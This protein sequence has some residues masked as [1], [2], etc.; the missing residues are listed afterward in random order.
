MN[1]EA[2]RRFSLEAA[3]SGIQLAMIVLLFVAAAFVLALIQAFTT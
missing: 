2:W 3:R 1:S